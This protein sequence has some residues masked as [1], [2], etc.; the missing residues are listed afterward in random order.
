MEHRFSNCFLTHHVLKLELFKQYLSIEAGS[1]VFFTNNRCFIF[2]CTWC[3]C[4][5]LLFILSN[6]M[7]FLSY[8]YIASLRNLWTFLSKCQYYV[9]LTLVVI[10][11]ECNRV[12]PLR[13]DLAN[14]K[15][16][17]SNLTVLVCLFKCGCR[18]RI[19]IFFYFCFTHV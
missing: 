14:G 4:C 12:D 6:N 17:S 19:Y 11:G 1:V 18:M 2:C 8:C 15:L 3:T 5:Y 16:H 9:S 7:R 10:S 13:I